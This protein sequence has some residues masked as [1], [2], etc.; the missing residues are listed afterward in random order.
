MYK[1]NS[2]NNLQPF[3][4]EDT[5]TEVKYKKASKSSTFHKILAMPSPSNILL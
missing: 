2:N 1:S 5:H 4:S 3:F